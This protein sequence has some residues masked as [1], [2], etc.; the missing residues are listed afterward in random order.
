MEVRPMENGTKTYIDVRVNGDPRGFIPKWIV[1]L[2]QKKWPKNTLEGIRKLAS[3]T[4]IPETPG[5]KEF[6]K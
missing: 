4:D 6:F 1:N 2:F 3:R 5:I